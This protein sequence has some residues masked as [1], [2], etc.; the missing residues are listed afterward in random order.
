ME[1]QRTSSQHLIYTLLVSTPRRSLADRLEKLNTEHPTTA[2]LADFQKALGQEC[3]LRCLQP[4]ANPTVSSGTLL[5]VTLYLSGPLLQWTDAQSGSFRDLQLR[6][7]VAALALLHH[8]GLTELTAEPHD[9]LRLNI[10]ARFNEIID[11]RSPSQM[12]LEHR[13]RKAD[14]RYLVRLA[15]QYFSLIKRAQPLSD[16]VPIP[17]IGLVLAGASIVGRSL[18]F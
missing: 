5:Q 16:A 13:M 7:L 11:G 14:A 3:L 15:A 6:A 8:S 10:A 12:S 4:N 1:A 2:D 18:V 9:Q 17:I